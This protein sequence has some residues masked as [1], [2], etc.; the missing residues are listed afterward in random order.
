[1]KT[2]TQTSFPVSTDSVN[3]SSTHRLPFLVQ[4]ILLT[5]RTLL[6]NLR[7]PGVFAFVPSLLIS[8]FS[9]II[10]Q[11]QLGNAAQF[12]LRGQS[13][14]G[15]I[16]PLSLASASLSGS[17]VASQT[18][19]NDITRGYFNKLLLTPANR[20]ALLLG[21][22]IANALLLIAQVVVVLL[23]GLLLGLKPAMGAFGLLAVLGFTVLLGISFSGLTV[24]VALLSGNSAVT[25]SASF[26]FFPLTFLTATFVPVD[27]LQ[28]W[29][30]VAAYINPITYF[31]EA[32]RSILN[33]GWNTIVILRGLLAIALMFIILFAF[34]LYSLRVRTR[35][36]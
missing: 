11:A 25:N 36:R 30:K 4:V 24:G 29:F 2:T 15:F 8:V 18:I 1:M 14:L 12:F 28:G 33:T 26:L 34:A 27:L 13:Y 10:Y 16:L 23:I 31:L 32:T 21:P 6:V 35:R 7:V 19:I 5:Q 20:W 9:L 17:S 3:T 22:M